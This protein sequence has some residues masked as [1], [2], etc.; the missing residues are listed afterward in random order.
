VQRDSYLDRRQPLAMQHL[1][2][3]QAVSRAGA[4]IDGRDGAPA[5]D[6]NDCE[7][8]PDVFVF[9]ASPRFQPFDAF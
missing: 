8:R 9:H 1:P 6:E 7:Q 2:H 3:A 5:E 4:L